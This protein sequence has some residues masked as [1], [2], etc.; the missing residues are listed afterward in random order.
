MVREDGVVA[1]N[2]LYERMALSLGGSMRVWQQLSVAA[3][4]DVALFQNGNKPPRY[5]SGAGPVDDLAAGDP[6]LSLKYVFHPEVEGH[7]GYAFTLPISLPF[8]NDQAYM[9]RSSLAV[10][11]TLVASLRRGPWRLAANLGTR[12]QSTQV[13]Y[14]LED[15]PVLHVDVAMSRLGIASALDQPRW[16]LDVAL[17]WQ[18]P[19]D[20]PFRD[21]YLERLEGQVSVRLPMGFGM[22]VLFG[23]G[24]GLW[25]G[26]GVPLVRPFMALRYTEPASAP[27]APRVRK[28]DDPLGVPGM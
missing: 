4:F 28:V 26:F 21:M 10:D 8:G 19:L 14:N 17:S 25:P 5:G 24:V 23:T 16:W 9:G 6:T 22:H 13:T 18:T 11:P 15:G 20:G 7:V 1:R 3:R 12:L 2:L 27:G